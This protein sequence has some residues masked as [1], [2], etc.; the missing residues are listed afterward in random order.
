VRRKWAIQGA[1]EHPR[2]GLSGILRALRYES[3]G[4]FFVYD[5]QGINQV[6]GPKPELEG[7][8]LSGLQDET[9]KYFIRDI[10]AAA[11]QGD[12]LPLAPSHESPHLN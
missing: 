5:D 10:I 2:F 3:D 6:L 1:G 7:K 11:R 8:D 12:G 9:G 4:Y